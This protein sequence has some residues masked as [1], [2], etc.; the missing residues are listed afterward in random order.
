MTTADES[1]QAAA[2]VAPAA[3]SNG[4]YPWR[5]LPPAPSG[6]PSTRATVHGHAA[7]FVTRAVGA[8]VDACAVVLAVAI[9]YVVVAGF[10]FLLHPRSFRF[11]APGFAVILL[12]VG[13]VLAAYL[14]VTWAIPGR[15]YGDQLMGLR[16]TDLSGNRLHWSR[17]AARALLYV[18]FPLGLGWVL[19]SAR[20][21]SVQDVVLRTTVV[22]D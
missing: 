18:L 5:T 9:G 21:R 8:T 2:P 15:T 14:T 16:V 19:V 7:G 22:Y 11:P 12:V 6:V 4:H 13:L 1:R 10:R 17:A 3:T 20:N